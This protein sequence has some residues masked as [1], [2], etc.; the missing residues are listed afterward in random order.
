MPYKYDDSGAIL[1]QD[2]DG[3]KLPVFIRDDGSEIP[4][5]GT[6]V[7]SAISRAND[8]AKTHRERAERLVEP[9]EIDRVRAE[10]A[11]EWEA[12]Y[13]PIVREVEVLRTELQRERIDGAFSRSTF[14]AEKVAVPADMLCASFAHHFKLEGGKAVAYIG[15]SPISSTV[16][17][18]QHAGFDEAIKALI[19]QSPHAAAIL[20]GSGAS[21][22]GATQTSSRQAAGP[23]HVTRAHFEALPPSERAAIARDKNTV[24]ID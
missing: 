14:I 4:L 2:V 18:G 3:Q 9:T 12:R 10:T 23:R 11:S 1:L 5:D 15:N 13:T 6:R 17:P 21:G 8:E 16:N 7:L 20:K 24:L 22:G 19:E